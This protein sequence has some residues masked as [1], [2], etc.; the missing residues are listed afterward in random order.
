MQDTSV[1]LKDDGREKIV[2]MFEKEQKIKKVL[3]DLKNLTA[4]FNMKKESRRK[5]TET[6]EL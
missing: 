1:K 5:Q 6:E 2:E 4:F 3:D